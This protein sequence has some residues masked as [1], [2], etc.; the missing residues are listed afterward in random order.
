MSLHPWELTP[1]T[2]WESALVLGTCE[3]GLCWKRGWFIPGRVGEGVTKVWG[4]W[5]PAHQS[6]VSGSLWW[7]CWGPKGRVAKEEGEAG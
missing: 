7:G 4:S 5:N 6:G 2:P 1:S 3:K